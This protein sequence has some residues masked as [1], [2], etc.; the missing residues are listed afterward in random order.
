MRKIFSLSLFLLILSLPLSAFAAD[1][2]WDANTTLEITT[3]SVNLTILSGSKASSFTTDGTAT[4]TVNVNAGENFTVKTPSG[5][6]TLTSSAGFAETCNSDGTRSM[7]IAA[8]SSGA[9]NTGITVAATTNTCNNVNVAGTSSGGGAV[10]GGGGSGSSANNASNTSSDS[11]SPA[12]KQTYVQLPTKNSPKSQTVT[13]LDVKFPNNGK[14]TKP[15]V[16]KD[17]DST[18]TYTLAYGKKVKTM[19]GK[20]FKGK[21]MSPK[22][23]GDNQIPSGFPEG[24]VSAVEIKYEEA[25][26]I[27]GKFELK[28]PVM[29]AGTYK[30][31]YYNTK[32][33]KWASAGT[34]KLSKD[35]KS[36]YVKTDKHGIFVLVKTG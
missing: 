6:F 27:S 28:M 33:K 8:P 5:S 11:K 23:L 29:E 19:S 21:V 18:I 10:S 26:K 17:G 14:V 13:D 1:I 16:M 4:F 3:P 12:E 15:T 22:A 24:A 32:T 25:V 34:T 7:I 9:V 31:F 30:I 35:K 36:A 20:P 2:E